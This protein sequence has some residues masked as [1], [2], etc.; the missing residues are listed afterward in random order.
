MEKNY[1]KV[2]HEQRLLGITLP[3]SK[4]GF[5]I[6]FNFMVI[7][8]ALVQTHIQNLF[9]MFLKKSHY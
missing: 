1:I 7:I 6:V 9:H 2:N 5:E 4:R 8:I 3:D